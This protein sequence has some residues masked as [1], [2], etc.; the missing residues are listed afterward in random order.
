MGSSSIKRG[1]RLD[2]WF[3]WSFCPCKLPV[4]RNAAGRDREGLLAMNLYSS[5]RHSSPRTL[6][7]YYVRLA[8]ESRRLISSLIP[9]QEWWPYKV[10][11][12]K[13]TVLRATS[14]SSPAILSVWNSSR[15]SEGKGSRGVYGGLEAQVVLQSRRLWIADPRR[16]EQ[17]LSH[18]EKSVGGFIQALEGSLLQPAV[19]KEE[20]HSFSCCHLLIYTL[21]L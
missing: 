3:T 10:Y 6:L 9:H 1:D 7:L 13:Q 8:V 15:F 2:G 16:E 4:R 20:A 5:L 17:W 19:Y 11:K 14:S 18:A 12:S 21:L